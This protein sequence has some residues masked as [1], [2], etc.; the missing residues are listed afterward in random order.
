MAEAKKTFFGNLLMQSVPQ[1]KAQKKN[2]VAQRSDPKK[3]TAKNSQPKSESKEKAVAQKCGHCHKEIVFA[4][5]IQ[6]IYC[7]FCGV[8][9]DDERKQQMKKTSMEDYLSPEVKDLIKKNRSKK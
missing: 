8:K 5:A 7:P 9:M 2:N 4:E 1:K 6:A 3:S